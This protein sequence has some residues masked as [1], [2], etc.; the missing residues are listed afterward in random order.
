MKVFSRIVRSGLI[1]CILCG[2]ITTVRAQ[3]LSDPNQPAWTKTISSNEFKKDLDFLFK[4]IEEVHPNMYAYTSKEEFAKYKDQLYKQIDRPMN[5]REL[6]KLVAPVVAWLRSLHTRIIMPFREEYEQY[7]KAGGKVFPLVLSWDESKV[8]LNKNYSTAALPLG[9]EVL[10]INGELTSELFARFEHW[11]PAE[12]RRTNP[13]IIEHPVS[14]RRLLF[15][16]YGTIESWHLSIKAKD[17][18]INSYTIPS[19]PLTE[20]TADEPVATI[21]REKHYRF[22]PEY[23]AALIKFYK[24]Q[25]PEKLKLFWDKA[26]RDI[27]EKNV[28]NLIIDIRENTGGSDQCFHPLLEHLTHKPFRLYDRVEMKIVPQAQERIEQLRRD[29]PEVFENKEEGDIVVFELPFQTPAD[30]RFRFAGRTFVL[31]GRRSFSASTVFA[32]I[33]KCFK[34]ATL[35]GEETGDPT[36][37]YADSIHFKLP[38]SDLEACVA[39]KLLVTACGQLNGRGVIPDYEVKQKPEDIAKGV[40][41][42]L[43]FTLDLIRK[44]SSEI[45]RK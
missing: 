37:L 1:W 42:V 27:S 6:F 29:I 41:T 45:P 43:Q 18:V 7:S 21:E 35:V 8:T 24:W 3:Q 33:V 13:W 38:N 20:F 28:S 9:G 15:F 36:T 34:I 40:D 17:G 32:S 44:S 31:I 5:R 22:I 19:L 25:E 23:D 39:S 26:F 10:T 14:L 12:N 4:T 2:G 16:E 11:F 30:N